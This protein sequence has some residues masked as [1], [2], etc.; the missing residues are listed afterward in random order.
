MDPIVIAKT[1]YSLIIQIHTQVKL[2][3][4]NH[5][6]CSGL[7][8]KIDMIEASLRRI[9]NLN[10]SEAYCQSLLK[11]QELLEKC[12]NF[13]KE[14]SQEGW[15]WHVL[16]AG[17]QAEKFD[18]FGKELYQAAQ[19]LGLDLSV[20]QLLNREKDLVCQK[21]DADFI[22][23]NQETIITLCQE[24][25]SI[26]QDIK[27]HQNEILAPQI[28]SI[29]IRLEE[30]TDLLE[31][32]KA[33]QTPFSS[34]SYIPSY[35][36]KFNRK[37]SQGKFSVVYEGR[38][39]NQAVAIKRFENSLGDEDE[40]IFAREVKM[41]SELH[42]P[43]VPR[44]FGANNDN[45]KGCIV[46]EYFPLGS[47]YDYCLQHTLT[48][49]Q[50][51][52]L[53]YDLT[54]GLN[55]LHRK[56]I[57]HANFKSQNILIFSESNKLSPK[58]TG[59]GLSFC[60]TASVASLKKISSAWIYAAPEIK[61]GRPDFT[62]AV[63]IYSFGTILWEI[64]SGR[65]SFAGLSEKE[66]MSKL[67]RGERESLET[68]P[69]FYA[70]IIRGCWQTDPLKRP[71]LQTI[72]RQ[73]EIKIAAHQAVVLVVDQPMLASKLE[74]KTT[75]QFDE[76]QG[77][78]EEK[79]KNYP[80]ARKWHEQAISKGSIRSK[81]NLAVLLLRGQGGPRDKSRAAVLLNEAANV[82]H[83]RAMHN[84]GL[85]LKSGDGIAKDAKLAAHHFKTA[86]EKDHVESMLE[87]A[88]MLKVGEG[89][90][91][92][93]ALADEWFAKAAQATKSVAY[94]SQRL[95]TQN[96]SRSFP[97]DSALFQLEPGKK[98]PDSAA[99]VEQ[100]ASGQKKEFS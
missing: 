72:S 20:Q 65:S 27:G 61:T 10:G 14:F 67:V 95:Q 50:K 81:T 87:F 73:L 44:F 52:I 97:N 6:Q 46:L 38:W 99:S 53:A 35:E 69:S 4:F 59:F 2:A 7:T 1:I 63:D 3:K 58:I 47:L 56:N 80:S 48:D 30:V 100:Q 54:L 74:S 23:R 66:L 76:S 25:L 83:I 77:L 86:A 89:V 29:R 70:E 91:Q 96:L 40:E 22:K 39:D 34:H 19:L 94:Q 79:N 55:F 49:L 15:F 32:A 41:M 51:L 11:L 28:A 92:D 71:N 18:S 68:I 93:L 57:V 85:M 8:E 42:S 78:T 13:I 45:R 88:K 24:V 33:K 84:Y 9:K 37:I 60:T 17:S 31:E 5:A 64:A 62:F 43:Y 36:L 82:G 98:Q 12:L 26:G 21:Q 75:V 16:K 90:S